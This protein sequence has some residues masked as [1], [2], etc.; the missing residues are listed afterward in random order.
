MSHTSSLARPKAASAWFPVAEKSFLDLGTAGSDM[1]VLEA[2]H[3]FFARFPRST[4]TGPQLTL[5][6]LAGAA[7]GI[8][9]CRSE[10]VLYIG[11][12]V[13]PRSH[14]VN[15]RGMHVC[16]RTVLFRRCRVDQAVD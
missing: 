12:V 1:I 13:Q 4:A 16:T 5:M 14:D 9:L 11:S 3:N 7:D 6:A 2:A 10:F 15:M 8:P